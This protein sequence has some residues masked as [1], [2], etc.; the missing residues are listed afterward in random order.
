MNSRLSSLVLATAV[1]LGCHPHATK[2][3]APYSATKDEV[4]VRHVTPGIVFKTVAAKRGDPLPSP[5]LTARV[6][7][8]EALT[9]PVFSPLRGRVAELRVRLGDHVKKGDRLMLVQTPELPELTRQRREAK[10][11]VALK[12]STVDRLR[13]LVVA[14]AVPEHDLEVA[15]TDL[16][17]AKV[18]VLS[19]EAKLRSL[20][21]A[22]AGEG[23][24]WM[25]SDR[26]GTVV[27]LHVSPGA[28][29]G[30]DS[31]SSRLR[32]RGSA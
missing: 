12:Q 1:T 15:Q 5:P 21:V 25:S 26:D 14:R 10:L 20:S 31:G 6:T 28:A 4:V 23:A 18:D 16:E 27:E 9:E 13:Q 19:A 2:D 11:A 30:P 3:A 24:Y 29:V 7:T 32:H 8:V 22:P 17:T